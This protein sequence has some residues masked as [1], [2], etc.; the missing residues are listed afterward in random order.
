M[1]VRQRRQG[2]RTM[3]FLAIAMTMMVAVVA[4]ADCVTAEAGQETPHLV[5][6]SEY[7]R[8]L[9]ANEN[10]REFSEREVLAENGNERL[11]ASIRGSTRIVL[12]L[13]SQISVLKGMHLNEPF[14]QLT[15][16]IA[17]FYQQKIELHNSM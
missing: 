2:G 8:E 14:D 12:E 13:N 10:A 7:I 16:T 11:M 15:E 5:F 6:V 9:S 4:L 17:A 1:P 3:R